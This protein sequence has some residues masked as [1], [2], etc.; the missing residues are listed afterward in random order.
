MTKMKKI[1]LSLLFVSAILCLSIPSFAIVISP[2]NGGFYIYQTAFIAH[3]WNGSIEDRKK[4]LC[5]YNRFHK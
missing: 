5:V 2:T 3:T 1:F 4:H